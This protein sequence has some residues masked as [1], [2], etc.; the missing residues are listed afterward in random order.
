MERR[1]LEDPGI[2]ARSVN[3]GQVL[4]ER[5]TADA[6]LFVPL[7]FAFLVDNLSVTKFGLPECGRHLGDVRIQGCRLVCSDTGFFPCDEGWL[8]GSS[9]RGEIVGEHFYSDEAIG[10]IR[11]AP[12]AG[13][14]GKLPLLNSIWCT[15][16]NTVFRILC[17]FSDKL[18]VRKENTIASS[19]STLA[20][21]A[22]MM[23]SQPEWSELVRLHRFVFLFGRLVCFNEGLSGFDGKGWLAKMMSQS[24]DYKSPLDVF[25][26]DVFSRSCSTNACGSVEDLIAFHGFP[27]QCTYDE[28]ES[29][30][31]GDATNNFFECGPDLDEGFGLPYVPDNTG[32]LPL[33]GILKGPSPLKEDRN[34]KQL[35]IFTNN[36]MIRVSPKTPKKFL[37]WIN[38]AA[39]WRAHPFTDAIETCLEHFFMQMV[40]SHWINHLL[41]DLERPPVSKQIVR[42]MSKAVWELAQTHKSTPFDSALAEAVQFKRQHQDKDSS[43]WFPLFHGMEIAILRQTKRMEAEDDESMESIDETLKSKETLE[44]IVAERKRSLGRSFQLKTMC[45]QDCTQDGCMCGK[46]FA[47]L[48][49]AV[50][51]LCECTKIW[52]VDFHCQRTKEKFDEM[53]PKKKGFHHP[54]RI[55]SPLV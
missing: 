49:V 30:N 5:V 4:T 32:R 41:C 21:I 13:L 8:D 40:Q 36:D 48:N 24:D 44:S 25:R 28:K 20:E 3:K 33:H 50:E 26:S 54:S 47:C 17:H 46:N 15:E 23:G 19:L 52:G 35:V 43:W 22:V 12:H 29:K 55:P 38:D 11:K 16:E 51:W 1:I 6:H 45:M 9:L 53:N 34:R 37:D 10:T 14:V 42:A 31:L 39:C 27:N 2:R 7:A 18:R